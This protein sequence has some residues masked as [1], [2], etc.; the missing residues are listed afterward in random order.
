M[1]LGA[2]KEKHKPLSTDTLGTV[3]VHGSDLEI[4]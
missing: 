1:K 4:T 3:L 2:Y